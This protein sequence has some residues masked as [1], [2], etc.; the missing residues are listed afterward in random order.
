MKKVT[1]FYKI[2]NRTPIA[3]FLIKYFDISLQIAGTVITNITSDCLINV[4]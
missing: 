3:A 4:T 1:F 2:I